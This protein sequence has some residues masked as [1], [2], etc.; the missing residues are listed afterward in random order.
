MKCTNPNCGGEWIPPPG[1]SVTVCPFC[2]E[3]IASEKKA[4][5]SFDSVMDTLIYIKEQHSVDMLLNEK[6]Y[7]FFADL[8]RNQLRD[9]V[10]LIKQFCEKNVLDCLKAG[11]GRPDSEH[12][13]AM[14]RAL[15]KLPKYLQDSPAVTDML[16]C[17][18]EALGWTVKSK[19]SSSQLKQ[20]QQSIIGQPLQRKNKSGTEVL[21]KKHYQIK[22]DAISNISDS[23]KADAA[24][25]R[26][27]KNKNAP[28]EIRK[29]AIEGIMD[30]DIADELWEEIAR[31]ENVSIEIRKEA[32]ESLS[33]SDIADELWEELAK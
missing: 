10:D 27:A 25:E 9:E 19:A 32:I 13:M 4:T 20:L 23:D 3:P 8:T 2:Q 21:D 12:E 14:K 24:Y 28:M 29:E 33:D 30:S 6:V 17:F 15:S 31:D 1:K 18:T 5:Q 16:F 26:L 7:T 11:I 22:L